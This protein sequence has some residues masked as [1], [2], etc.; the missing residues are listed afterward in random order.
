MLTVDSA[1]ERRLIPSY[2]RHFD[3]S[4]KLGIQ[5]VLAMVFVGVFWGILYLGAGLFDLIKIAWFERLIEKSWFAFPATTLALALAIHVTDV[6]P[7]LIRGVRSLALTLFS[8]LLPLLAGI[9][10][11]FLASLAVISLTPLWNTHFAGALLLVAAG[12]M[13]FL[14]NGCYQDGAAVSTLPQIKRWGGTHGAIELI[15][16]VGLAVWALMLRVEQYGWTAERVLAAAVAI[17]AA[18]YA[19]G[20]ASAAIGGAAMVEAPRGHQCPWPPISCW[21]S[22]WRCSRR[23]RTRRA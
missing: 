15:P 6:Q 13:V 21:P 2:S 14:I 1:I 8:W 17:V 4:W 22:V 20:Y 7:A 9:L 10:L 18:C 23:R 16:L 3:T 11:L 12:V 19:V 5:I